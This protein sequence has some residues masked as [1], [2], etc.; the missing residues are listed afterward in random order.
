MIAPPARHRRVSCSIAI[1]L[2]S[3]PF[4]IF[5]LVS[6]PPAP[7]RAPPPLVLT[8]VEDVQRALVVP[9]AP[10][11]AP[12][13]GR[14]PRPAP[15]ASPT[16]WAPSA[17]VAAPPPQLTQADAVSTAPAA[18]A[19]LEPPASAPLDLGSDVLRKAYRQGK[20]AVR[21]LADNSHQELDLHGPT[22]AER[23]AS[24]IA[25]AGMPNCLAPDAM[26]H[27]PPMIGPIVVGGVLA[28]PFLAR[29]VLTGKCQP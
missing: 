3:V 16:L 17:S 4:A 24:A 8:L 12:P 29:T 18:A 14:S 21:E 27:D 19:A 6:P 20:S 15:A 9:A 28:I 11:T 7:V 13:G 25:D 1:A 5:L 10:P 26:K 23:L 22:K 2:S